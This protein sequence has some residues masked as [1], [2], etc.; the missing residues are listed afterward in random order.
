MSGLTEVIARYLRRQMQPVPG[1]GRTSICEEAREGL[2]VLLSIPVS[3]QAVLVLPV[4][5]SR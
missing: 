4:G 2:R 1:R 5:N 3:V